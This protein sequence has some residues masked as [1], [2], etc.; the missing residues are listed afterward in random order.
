MAVR[1]LLTS[2]AVLNNILAICYVLRVVTKLCRI[3]QYNIHTPY[4]P[5]AA[6]IC[7]IYGSFYNIKI[8]LLRI[9]II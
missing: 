3:K 7:I 5:N 4:I 1:T 8:Y 2:L 9:Y 6:Y